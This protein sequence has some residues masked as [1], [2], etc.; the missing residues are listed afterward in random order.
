MHFISYANLTLMLI[1]LV[2]VALFYWRWGGDAG[3][4]GISTV[5]MVVQL[6]LVGY[7]L[8]SLFTTKSSVL[9]MLMV[10]VMIVVSGWIA[11]HN[12]K[13]KN[14]IVYIKI[15]LAI[16][17]GGTIN[18][19]WVL[20]FILKLPTLIEPRVVIPLA[21]MI[22]A[23]AMN[24]VS[25]AAER[26]ESE[27]EDHTYL[28]ARKIALRAAMIPQINTFLAVGLVALPGMM[29]GQILS[30]ID[31]MIAVRYQIVVMAM[32]LSSGAMSSML[33][34]AWY[35]NPNYNKA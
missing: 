30:G 3:E 35:K 31:P 23:N 8:T 6:I 7:I 11:L 26:L 17:I 10:L 20:L 16:A 32:V 25:L 14:K 5:R 33:Y 13:V 24:M 29:T 18:L 22:Y 4:I 2:S 34:L 28:I 12:L 1:P 9:L 15:T 21:G 19:L 27:I